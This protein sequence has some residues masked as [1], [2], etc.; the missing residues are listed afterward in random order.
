MNDVISRIYG[1]AWSCE[2]TSGKPPPKE[3]DYASNR[4][5]ADRDSL[6]TLDRLERDV[7]CLAEW[8]A[9]ARFWID[10]TSGIDEESADVSAGP[11]FQSMCA[12]H[13]CVVLSDSIAGT[14]TGV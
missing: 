2:T 6:E 13:H 11:E 8:F 1:E 7:H 9:G 5:Q 4:S 3:K 12:R 14:C 10:K